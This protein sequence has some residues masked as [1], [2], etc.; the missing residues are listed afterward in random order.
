VLAI[1][2]RLS[3]QAAFQYGFAAAARRSDFVHRSTA[4]GNSALIW[5][6]R[7]QGRLRRQ[8]ANVANG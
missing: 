5:L 1:D 2:E 6:R 4:G 8:L 3:R 7:L